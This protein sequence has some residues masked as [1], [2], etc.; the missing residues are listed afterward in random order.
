MSDEETR[1]WNGTK[2][3]FKY[4][5]SGAADFLGPFEGFDLWFHASFQEV[6]FLWKHPTKGAVSIRYKVISGRTE[7]YA[8]YVDVF[9]AAVQR[10]DDLGLVPTVEGNLISLKRGPDGLVDKDAIPQLTNWGSY[11]V[12]Q[13][14]DS[15]EG[16]CERYAETYGFDYGES[17]FQRTHVW[18]EEQQRRYVEHIMRGGHSGR[19]L[20][21]NVPGWMGSSKPGKM[22]LVDGK[23]RLNAARL[24]MKNELSIFNG[25]YRKDIR[26]KRL[27]MTGPGFLWHVNNLKTEAE[28]LQWYLDINRGGTVH[29]D[30]EI[31][32][33]RALLEKAAS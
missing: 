4:S 24:F 23:Q 27:S 7:K 32:K 6:E 19:D 11:S 1:T 28:V 20:L 25:I 8:A 26:G 16:A 9:K 21:T 2:P 5:G 14:W 10:A 17:E 15:I 22:V 31:A 18:T 12:M 13:P 30:D 33:V 3:R 29:T